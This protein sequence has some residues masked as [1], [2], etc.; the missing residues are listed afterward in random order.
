MQTLPEFLTLKE[1]VFFSRLSRTTIWKDIKS[2]LLKKCDNTGRK[3][4]VHRDE[5]L[6]FMGVKNIQ[7]P[8]AA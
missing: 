3:V 6:R 8:Q 4:I 7:L 5:F 2:G 1:V